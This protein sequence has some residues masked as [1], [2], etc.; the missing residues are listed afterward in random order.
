MT[1]EAIK[2]QLPDTLYQ[3]L[4]EIADASKK[5]LSEVII[6]SIQT[7]LPPSLD[8][9]PDRFQA[10]LRTLNQLDN[11]LLQD[12]V[13]LDLAIDKTKLYEEL[14]I[15]NQ[16]KNL[17]PQEHVILDTLRE[18]ADVLMLRRAYAAAILKWRGQP[19]P[20]I[21]DLETA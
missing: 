19:I 11:D 8:H 13:N 7:G 14:L 3:H 10:D 2:L 17:E 9:V 15:K 12:V 4:T 20:I 21:D 5:S 6:Q 18:E 1:V 16:Q